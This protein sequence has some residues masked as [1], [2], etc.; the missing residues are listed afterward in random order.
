MHLA[1]F[2]ARMPLRTDLL[3]LHVSGN[4]TEGN[5]KRALAGHKTIAAMQ[6]ILCR[7]I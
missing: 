5:F 7:R 2:A 3:G 6:S 4:Q 1:V